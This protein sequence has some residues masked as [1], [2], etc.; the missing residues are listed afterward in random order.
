MQWVIRRHLYWT[1]TNTLQLMR[2][3]PWIHCWI[4]VRERLKKC[5]DTVSSSLSRWLCPSWLGRWWLCVCSKGNTYDRQLE[6]GE[7][8]KTTKQQHLILDV[9][10][11][12][13]RWNPWNEIRGFPPPCAHHRPPHLRMRQWPNSNGRRSVGPVGTPSAAANA[14]GRMGSP[15]NVPMNPYSFVCPRKDYVWVSL[16]HTQ[17]EWCLPIRPNGLC[18]WSP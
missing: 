18:L 16:S 1:H 6:S 10:T 2:E 15:M 11:L 3:L 8:H 14:A 13:P 7:H 4:R 12:S 17:N 5:I 9:F